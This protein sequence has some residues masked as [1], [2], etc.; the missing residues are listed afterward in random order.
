MVP[1]GYRKDMMNLID[2][3]ELRTPTYCRKQSVSFNATKDSYIAAKNKVSKDSSGNEEYDPE[4]LY[5]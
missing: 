3:V 4:E 1:K 5:Q 2:L